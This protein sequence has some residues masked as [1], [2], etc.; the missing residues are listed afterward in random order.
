MTAL[1]VIGCILLFFVLL[2]SLKVTLTVAYSD[3]L[4]L[5]ARVLFVK[6]KILPKKENKRGPH[7]MSAKKAEKIKRRLEKKAEKKRAKAE[8]KRQK[9]QAKKELEKK[10]PK[11]KKSLSEI[12]DIIG[13][14]TEV[15]K[16]TVKTFFGHLRVKVARLHI[17]VAT[18]D[19]A[20]TAIAYGAIT[21]AAFY[22]FEVLEPL[23][24]V[25]MPAEKDVSINADFLSDSFT[26]DIKISLSIRVWHVL[27]TALA[28]LVAFIKRFIKMKANKE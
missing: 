9:K 8:E 1:I 24:G 26:A 13:T 15:V 10:Q 14:V 22:L 23:D 7:S 11:E 19:A 27:H 4:V 21:E 28:A 17:N 5:Y 6:I 3:E 20:T 16:K 25:S 18:G 12:L 2:L